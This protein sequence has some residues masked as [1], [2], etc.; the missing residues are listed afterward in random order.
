[1][2]MNDCYPCAKCGSNHLIKKH[3][4]IGQP[5]IRCSGCINFCL[6]QPTFDMAVR[7]WNRYFG[8]IPVEMKGSENMNEEKKLVYLPVS[9]LFPHPNNPRKDLGDLTELTES[10]KANGILQNLTVVP[11]HRMSKSEYIAAAKKEGV[12]KTDAE[13]T[14]DPETLDPEGYT[15][16]IGHRRLSAAK[17]AGLDTV[18]CVIMEMNNLEQIRT[19][20]IENMHRT[21][22]TPIEQADSFQM[23]LDLGDTVQTIAG[24][25]GFSE[26]T[27]RNRL[28]LRE[29]DRDKLNAATERGGTLQDY[30][31]LQKVKDPKHRDRV[32]DAIGTANFKNELESVLDG[33]QREE[34]KAYYVGEIKK[35]AKH[36]PKSEQTYN[37]NWDCVKTYSLREDMEVDVP[38]DTDKV[39]YYY[40][41]DGSWAVQVYK[42]RAKE[43]TKREKK[44]PEQIAWDHWF[45]E[46]TEKLGDIAK[47]H[48]KLRLD[49]VKGLSEGT[50][51]KKK[52]L[53][54]IVTEQALLWSG[55]SGVDTDKYWI[56]EFVKEFYDLEKAP[57]D[58]K[59]DSET[60][61]A[62]LAKFRSEPTKL[63]LVTTI[64]ALEGH[65]DSIPF[66]SKDFRARFDTYIDADERFLGTLKEEYALLAKLGYEISDEESKTMNG[67]LLKEL[68]STAPEMPGGGK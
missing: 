64:A 59:D 34:R 29:Y 39:D 11:G 56:N 23:M 6:P 13:G 21:D 35:F 8:Q 44:S 46:T 53:A 61:A 63:L 17:A 66:Y 10:I 37:G 51:I 20:A 1:M 41:D 19:M 5:Y 18:P 3:N 68:L 48:K 22:L 43:K 65:R 67:E 36:F 16:I 32:L 9:E 15:V 55:Y 62:Y 57:Y 26:T 28:K 54:E 27:V 30:M 25:T 52:P 50:L 24:S 12:S 40:T 2:T 58:L 45:K 33:E 38:D 4:G 7:E 31:E 47:R 14:Y 42:R 60:K 49:F